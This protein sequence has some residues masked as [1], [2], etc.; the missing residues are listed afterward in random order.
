MA[1]VTQLLSWIFAHPSETQA[2]V[3]QVIV[4]L[5]GAVATLRGLVPWLRK[6]AAFTS[7]KADDGFVAWL[8]G[9]L[10]WSARALEWAHGHLSRFTIRGSKASIVQ[11]AEPPKT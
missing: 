7:T 10:D 3:L 6:A 1:H 2:Y 8:S 5:T 9:A 4:A 11:A